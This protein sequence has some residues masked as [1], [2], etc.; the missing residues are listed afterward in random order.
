MSRA[1]TPKRASDR[2]PDDGT[3]RKRLRT[4]GAAERATETLPAGIW[5][6]HKRWFCGECGR[7]APIGHDKCTCCQL[8]RDTVLKGQP[9]YDPKA[10]VILTELRSRLSCNQL[11]AS[12][13][14]GRAGCP[15]GASAGASKS[16]GEAGHDQRECS[17]CL[18]DRMQRFFASQGL[19]DLSQHVESVVWDCT[20]TELDRGETE[21]LVGNVCARLLHDDRFRQCLVDFRHHHHR[22]SMPWNV[23]LVRQLLEEMVPDRLR[24]FAENIA[25][26]GGTSTESWPE[27]ET[28]PKSPPVR[29]AAALRGRWSEPGVPMQPRECGS[30]Y[31][32]DADG[33]ELS[34][35]KCACGIF[36]SCQGYC[37]C[38]TD[39]DP[40]GAS[41]DDARSNGEDGTP[42]SSEEGS[43]DDAG[44]CVY[45]AEGKTDGCSQLCGDCKRRG[46]VLY[47]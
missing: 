1:E 6:E 17:L 28:Q 41:S 2:E 45:C 35:M 16:E 22:R 44:S 26:V 7:Q 14:C 11:F 23:A 36:R 21:D 37:P 38:F 5:R 33:R 12:E 31:T 4:S 19:A 25:Y 27:P 9:G 29:D 46:A 42:D 34:Q 20:A 32:F 15:R 30:Y 39:W 10:H 13:T 3:V 8:Y 24:G 18:A 47:H 40:D 43:E